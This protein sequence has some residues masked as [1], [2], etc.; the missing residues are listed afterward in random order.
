VPLFLGRLDRLSTILSLSQNLRA[1]TQDAYIVAPNGKTSTGREGN[2]WI[3]AGSGPRSRHPAD[4]RSPRSTY[5]SDFQAMAARWCPSAQ[6]RLWNEIFRSEPLCQH[7]LTGMF[8]DGTVFFVYGLAW[9]IR[10]D[11]LDPATYGPV[12]RKPGTAFLPSAPVGRPLGYVQSTGAC[13]AEDPQ[14]PGRQ[15]QPHSPLRRLGVGG[16]LLAAP[17]FTNWWACRDTQRGAA[18]VRA[19]RLVPAERA[20]QEA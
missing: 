1:Q 18:R 9:G 11:L 12:C 15:A 3:L 2:G 4:H 16:F 19:E 5:V 20:E 8:G 6:R 14:H 13:P 17:R 10:K 7:R